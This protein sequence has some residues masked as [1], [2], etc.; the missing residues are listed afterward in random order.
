MPFGTSAI[1]IQDPESGAS[2]QIRPDIGFNCFSFRPVVNGKA[3]EVIQAESDFADKGGSPTRNGIPLLF[4]F[5]GRIRNARYR[6]A[7]KDYHVTTAR[8]NG[9]NAIHGFVL[10]RRWR[11]TDYGANRVV[12]EFQGSIDAPETVAEWPSDYRIRATYTVTGASFISDF[13][14]SNPGRSPLPF[15]FG[16]HPYFKIPLAGGDPAQCRAVV[17]A[18]ERWTLVDLLPTGEHHPVAPDVDF[19]TGKSFSETTVDDVLSNLASE[20]GIV[21]TMV[22]DASTGIRVT[23]N[24]PDRFRYCIVYT[25]LERNAIA[26]EPYTSLVDPFAMTDLGIDPELLVL[27]PGETWKTSIT[28]SAEGM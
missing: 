19:R 26:I 28:I 18:S 20:N 16:T 25:P 1:V 2:A 13:E 12:G 8:P 22:E 15:S 9:D 21:T 10:D 4:P 14:I 24:F 3:V 23:Q 6:Y 27:A 11:V 17:P 7:G 5:A